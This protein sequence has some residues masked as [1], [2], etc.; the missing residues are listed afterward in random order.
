MSDSVVMVD[1]VPLITILHP[2]P[3]S[4]PISPASATLFFEPDIG[5]LH[6]DRA[7]DVLAGFRHLRT[8]TSSLGTTALITTGLDRAMQAF[9]DRL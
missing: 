6:Q 7:D 1:P 2:D 9:E 5:K 8:G 4:R 3:K